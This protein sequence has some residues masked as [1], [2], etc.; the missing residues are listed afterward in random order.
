MRT[1]DFD[2]PMPKDLIAQT[3]LESRDHSRLMV[4]QRSTGALEHSHFYD[5]GHFLK[6]GDLLVLNDS[7]VIPARLKGRKLD[8]GGTVEVLLLQRMG[9]GLWKALVKPGRRLAPGARFEVDGVAGE[10]IEDAGDGTRLIYLSNEDVIQRAGEMPLPPYIH[11]H[12]TDRERYQTVYARAEGSAAAPTAGLHFTPA[13]LESLGRE[14]IRFT[15]V[16]LHVG[17][18]TFRP[19]QSEEPE[20]HKLHSEYFELDEDAAREIN[21]A[22]AEGRRIISVG[23][24]SVR[25]LEQ[26]AL[27]SQQ[28]DGTG[29]DTSVAP[30]SGW[31]DLFILPGYRFQLVD[32]LI[33]NF[34]LPRSTLLM[35]V[36]AFAGRDPVMDAYLEAIELGYRLYSFGDCM[37]LL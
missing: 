18:D 4:M 16:T 13:L 24:T 15:H 31:V 25:V 29:D 33:T 5:I 20:K 3:P 30:V 6:P 2:Y 28:V 8:T 1:S 27:L 10:V 19:V 23:T 26:T 12:L 32:G 36:C 37:L 14:G 11:T 34:H 9:T 7:R 17:L 35:L 22:R 21:L